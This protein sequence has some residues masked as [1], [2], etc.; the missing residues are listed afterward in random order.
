MS[1]QLETLLVELNKFQD[2]LHVPELTDAT[3]DFINQLRRLNDALASLGIGG[4]SGGGGGAAVR[5]SL[6]ALK[7]R[8]VTTGL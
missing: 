3:R 7:R 8:N 4:G 2:G 6:L 5:D 1:S